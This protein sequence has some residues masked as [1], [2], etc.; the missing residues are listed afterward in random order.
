[1]ARAKQGVGRAAD[2]EAFVLV[3]EDRFAIKGR[4]VSVIGRYTGGPG[5]GAGAEVV[6][7]APG[8]LPIRA[9]LSGRAY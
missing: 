4:G 6:I 2:G 7:A 3:V 9:V 8:R 1:M 5:P